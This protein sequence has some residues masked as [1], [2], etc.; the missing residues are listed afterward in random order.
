MISYI[1]VFTIII[2]GVIIWQLRSNTR[3]LRLSHQKYP[4]LSLDILITKKERKIDEFIIRVHAKS[5][6]TI[7][8]INIELISKQREFKHLSISEV[9]PELSLPFS[10]KH[11]VT[12][13]TLCSYEVLKKAITESMTHL[14]S[15]RIVLEL[16]NNKVYKSHELQFDKLWKIYKSDTG[17]YN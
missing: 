13:D 2:I 9:F 11:L 4:E 17:K 15:F 7:R 8:E 10:I 1:I 6:I 3:Y 5:D 14:N 16:Q 12:T